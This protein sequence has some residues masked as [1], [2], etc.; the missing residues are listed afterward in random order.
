MNSRWGFRS[1]SGASI[2]A[3][4]FVAVS[5][6]FD[7]AV[8]Q[9]VTDGSVGARR[10]FNGGV[11]VIGDDL[12]ARRGGNLFHS[13]SKFDV[14]SGRAAVFGVPSGVDNVIGRVTGG[15]ASTID[16]VVSFADPT[17]TLPAAADFW[18][19]NPNGVLIGPGAQFRT[20]GALHISSGDTLLQ[21]GGDRFSADADSA[22]TLTSA[23]PEAFGFLR[24]DPG[25]LTVTGAALPAIGDGLSLSGGEIVLD[26]ASLF[27]QTTGDI[28][29]FAGA[30]GDVAR[31]VGAGSG[32]ATPTG[33]SIRLIGGPGLV[34]GRPAGSVETD[35]GGEIGLFAGSIALEGGSV[36]SRAGGADGGGVSIRADR[37]TLADGGTLGTLTTGPFDAGALDVNASAILLTDGGAIRS[38]TQGAGDA[39]AIA[40]VGFETLRIT[41][42]GALAET[43]IESEVSTGAAGDA[44][45]IV[46]RGGALELID[47]GRILSSTFGDGDAGSIEIAATSI[48]GTGGAQI[49]SGAL[50]VPFLPGTGAGRGGFV[51]VRASERIA[52]DGVRRDSP[53][54]EPEASGVFT[55]SEGLFTG[56]GGD[57][58]ASAPEIILT[59][60]AEIGAET[61]NS[62]PA[63]NVTLRGD[64]L[65][66]SGGS[67][68]STTSRAQGAAGDVSLIFADRVV[69]TDGGSVASRATGDGGSAGRVL[70]QTGDLSLFRGSQVTTA[71]T[72]ADGGSI[73]IAATGVASVDGSTVSTSVGGSDGDGGAIALSGGP[74]VLRGGSRLE[75][76]ALLGDGGTVTIGSEVTFI[77]IGSLIDV[78]SS[79]GRDGVVSILG[80]VGTQSSETEPPPAEFFNRFALVDDFCVAAVTSGS[81]LR[82]AP[83]EA[84]APAAAPG[85]FGGVIPYPAGDVA[86]QPLVLTQ[87]GAPGC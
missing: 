20:N 27:S 1:R 62:S 33:G 35:A 38:Q 48:V 61:F 43:A 6:C 55:G 79:A 58:F 81:A 10:T 13:F 69:L 29:V 87:S 46:I 70:I 65:R 24:G 60:R 19:F 73:A 78:S 45:S 56:P 44:G 77:E 17:F 57:L 9:V 11:A 63:G 25:P 23:A 39:G 59:N 4:L 83:Q 51:S 16:G 30:Q 37:L 32:A 31:I 15:Q 8:A 7:L 74:L 14:Q 67:E 64:V 40:V 49:A 68:I 72:S 47:G 80:V 54:E 84:P 76:T 82:L 26:G 36:L 42:N 50:D 75:S 66:A 71:S 86:A 22:L 3:G 21:S 28:M 52:F 41:R 5:V 18:F 85:F 34:N 2:A 12:G 53:L